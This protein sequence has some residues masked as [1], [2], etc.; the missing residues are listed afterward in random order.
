MR[1]E[2][3]DA[4]VFASGNTPGSV[5]AGGAFSFQVSV[6]GTPAPT[7]SLTSAPS[8][9]TIHPTTGVVSWT[10]NV[11]PGDYAF[12]VQASNSAGSATKQFIVR[13]T[14]AVPALPL[15]AA[16]MLLAALLGCMIRPRH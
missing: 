9:M 2:I 10:A 1:V 16:A 15:S 12:S 4:P 14:A 13:V 5:I 6:T 3:G 11:A 8:G 7:F